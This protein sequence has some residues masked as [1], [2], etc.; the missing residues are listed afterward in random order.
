MKQILS[1]VFAGTF[2][3]THRL[4]CITNSKEAATMRSSAYWRPQGQV[5]SNLRSYK[6]DSYAVCWRVYRQVHKALCEDF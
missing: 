4:K 3:T 2:P 6:S 5:H 1:K